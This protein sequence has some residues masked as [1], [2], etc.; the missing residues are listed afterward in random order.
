MIA[1]KTEWFLNKSFAW[2]RVIRGKD[3]ERKTAL[4]IIIRVTY[5]IYPSTY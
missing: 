1:N 4:N 5:L 2:I 3:F